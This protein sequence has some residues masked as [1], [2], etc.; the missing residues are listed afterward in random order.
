MSRYRF[1]AGQ[2]TVYPLRRLCA[3]LKVSVSG[4]YDWLKR[5]PSRRV[6]ANRELTVRIRAV[7]EAS[8]QTYGA[9]R[10]QAE[11]R[12]Q[13]ERVGKQRIARLMREMGLQTKG[14]RRFKTTTQRTRHTDVRRTCW[15]AISR[16]GG[17]TRSGCWDIT[18]IAT[19]EGWLYLAGIQDVFSRRIVGWSMSERPTKTLVCDAWELAVGQRGAPDL[20]HSDQG[21]QYTS[22]DYLRLLEKDEVILSMSDVDAATTMPC[23]KASGA[24]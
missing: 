15:R 22:D 13:G 11:L 6:Q 7:H 18:Y 19:H 10:V 2:R 21:S 4:Y 23:R 16:P 1:I 24:R 8:R 9:L 3:V 12:A 20:H 17:P 14:R 5:K